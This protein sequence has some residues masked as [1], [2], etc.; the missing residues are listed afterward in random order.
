M[1]VGKYFLVY[2]CVNLFTIVIDLNIC[3][4][5]GERRVS[6]RDWAVFEKTIANP[7]SFVKLVVDRN[8]IIPNQFYSYRTTRRSLA[9]EATTK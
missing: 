3:F 6:V 9:K 7:I 2:K 5:S 8:E 1:F 4:R